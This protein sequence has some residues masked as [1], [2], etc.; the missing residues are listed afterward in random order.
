MRLKYEALLDENCGV[1]RGFC[2]FSR[3]IVFD[4]TAV[5]MAKLG[6]LSIAY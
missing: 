4:F 2:G 5:F 3:H 6:Y 1:R